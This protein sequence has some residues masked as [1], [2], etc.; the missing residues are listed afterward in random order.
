MDGPRRVD[1]KQVGTIGHHFLRYTRDSESSD[2]R[3]NSEE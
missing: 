2:F 1:A 3:Y